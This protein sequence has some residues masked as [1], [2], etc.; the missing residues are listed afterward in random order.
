MIIFF[1]ALFVIVSIRQICQKD[2]NENDKKTADIL[3]QKDA[4]DQGEQYFR[5]VEDKIFADLV[6]RY[7]IAEE[8]RKKGDY[9]TAKDI[10]RYNIRFPDAPPAN[11]TSL[12]KIYRSEGDLQEELNILLRFKSFNTDKKQVITSFKY[13]IEERVPILIRRINGDLNMSDNDIIYLWKAKE[14]YFQKKP[15]YKIGITSKRLGTERIKTVSLTSGFDFEILLFRNSKRAKYLE[16]QMLK[17]GD[18]P[19]FEK[20]D[21]CTEFRALDDLELKFVLEIGFEI[22]EES[23][24]LK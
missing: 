11:Y 22:N 7:L 8:L 14:I 21:G 20:F 18:I 15:V 24:S 19:D 10:L 17:I 23:T 2:S 3:K 12:A 16:S 5:R 13:L 4:S 1:S 9:D 6:E